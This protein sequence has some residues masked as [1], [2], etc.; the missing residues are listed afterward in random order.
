MIKQK[1][2]NATKNKDINSMFNEILGEGDI[3]PKISYDK[4]TKLKKEL[5]E[6]ICLLENFALKSKI[7]KVKDYE[8]AM[9][10]ILVF[11]K[12]A[13][14]E[15]DQFMKDDPPFTEA[16]TIIPGT[17]KLEV[18]SEFSKVYKKSKEMSIISKFI[19]TY[20]RLLEYRKN[21]GDKKD[22]NGA[23]I[24][25][26]AGAEFCPLSFSSLNIKQAYANPN[27]D[28]ETKAYLLYALSMILEYSKNIYNLYSSPD[29]DPEV[30]KAIMAQNIDNMKKKF[31]NQYSE[32]F[33]AINNSIDLLG[34]N[35]NG[36]YKDFIA[37][38]NPSTM[39]E[40]F[41]NDVSENSKNQ[42]P[43]LMMQFNKIIAEYRK[44]SNNQKN[45]PRLKS[46]FRE[47]SD[48]ETEI[49]KKELNAENSENSSNV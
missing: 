12:Q 27:L 10:E 20:N 47:V 49:A 14:I 43:T 25:N 33:N 26:M 4:Y 23:F 31:G 32:A 36:Y 48:L 34:T 35:M 37:T 5:S 2:I 22:L 21:L 18:I 6:V 30:F 28:S 7:S 16:E 3:P 29:W 38:K 1:I 39:L 24:N 46:L 41:I 44:N 13:K 45:D 9:A 15:M 11:T 17:I 19:I 40:S 42:S 8:I